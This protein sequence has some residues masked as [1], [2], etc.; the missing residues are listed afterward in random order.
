MITKIEI[1]TI[2]QFIDEYR[3]LSNFYKHKLE[4]PYLDVPNLTICDSVEHYFQSTKT[5]ILKEKLEIL[6]AKNPSDAKRLGSKIT[7][8][9]DWELVKKH[10]MFKGLVY[11][12]NNL[13]LRNQLLLTKGVLLVEG[14]YWKDVYWGYDI[15]LGYGRN[16]L[17]QQLMLLRNYIMNNSTY[18]PELILADQQLQE[19]F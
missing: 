7:L 10:I 13:T 11:K 15:K 5:L 4:I 8:R 2:L 19:K 17:G 1:P 3:F 18:N 9:P 14:N 16:M 12:F 6:S